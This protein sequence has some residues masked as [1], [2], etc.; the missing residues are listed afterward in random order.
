MAL[1]SD[2]NNA[3]SH[4][5]VEFYENDRDPYKGVPFV[6]ILIP[7]DKT[8]EVD[9]PVRED[10][11]QR[12]PRQWLYYSMRNEN[13]A[14]IGTALKEWNKEQPEEFTDLQMA[15]LQIYKFQ[16]VEQL[17]TASDSQLQRVGMGAVG[18][19]ERARQF[20]A[21]KNRSADAIELDNTK[22]QLKVL[23]AQM[24]ELMN[25]RGPGRPPKAA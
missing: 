18:L 12:F 21:L 17:A 5:H 9:Q 14:M 4:L 11:K 24:Q 7:G 19:R 10:H 1:D 13:P 2:I 15:E 16:T 25:K 3:D 20:L 22:Q 6:R 8:N 23:Q